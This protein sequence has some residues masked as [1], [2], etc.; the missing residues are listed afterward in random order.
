MMS[1]FYGYNEYSPSFHEKQ[2]YPNHP[3]PIFSPSYH[4]IEGHQYL[5][6]AAN[7]YIPTQVPN[8]PQVSQLECLELKDMKKQ[9]DS[10]QVTLQN[11]TE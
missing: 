4:V 11:F 5:Q 8:Q 9:Q 3:K 6:Y 10:L 1:S 7:Q 2:P